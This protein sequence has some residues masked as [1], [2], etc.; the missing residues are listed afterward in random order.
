MFSTDEVQR[1]HEKGFEL[2]RLVPCK[3]TTRVSEIVIK[4]SSGPPAN[5]TIFVVQRAILD[6][7]AFRRFQLVKVDRYDNE[8]NTF[9][10]VLSFNE[11]E[12]DEDYWPLSFLQTRKH[13]KRSKEWVDRLRLS[14][15][16]SIDWQSFDSRMV[17]IARAGGKAAHEFSEERIA[18]AASDAFDRQALLFALENK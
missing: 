9:P 4:P 6:G 11:I 2:F 5:S 16:A 12:D 14:L 8:G 15:P 3:A 10:R 18:S 1:F 13:L 17:A 7:W